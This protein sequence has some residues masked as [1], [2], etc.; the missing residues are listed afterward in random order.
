MPQNPIHPDE[1]SPQQGSDLS[2][3]RTALKLMRGELDVAREDIRALRSAWAAQTDMPNDRYT[4]GEI[5]LQARRQGQQ[6]REIMNAKTPY[7]EIVRAHEAA[8]G[9][10]GRV[11]ALWWTVL[12]SA[13]TGVG[14]WFAG[15]Y[16]GGHNP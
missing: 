11:G 8:M 10:L 15:R 7:A 5:E 9:Y 14:A 12:A 2:E 16:G 3:L 6:V 13:I 1:P 4:M